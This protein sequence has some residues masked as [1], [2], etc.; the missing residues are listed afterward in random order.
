MSI[1]AMNQVW[2][3]SKQSGG[4]LLL[5]LAIADCANERGYCWPGDEYLAERIRMSERNTKRLIVKLEASGE[6]Y[7]LSHEGRGKK[8]FYIVATGLADADIECILIEVFKVAP[9]EAKFDIGEWRAGRSKKSQIKGDNMSPFSKT[10][11][12]EMQSHTSDKSTVSADNRIHP[13]AEQDEGVSLGG[14]REVESPEKSQ[15]KGDILSPFSGDSPVPDQVKIDDNAGAKDDKPS[16]GD[17]SAGEKGD[18]RGQKDD[19]SGSPYKEHEP[20][21]NPHEPPLEPP[22]EPS[23]NRHAR[24]AR[25]DDSRPETGLEKFFWTLDE[26][27]PG[28][29]NRKHV[30]EAFEKITRKTATRHDREL[31]ELTGAQFPFSS[32]CVVG[33]MERIKARACV[34][35]GSFAYF[36]TG[37]GE[38]FKRCDLAVKSAAKMCAGASQSQARAILLRAVRREIKSWEDRSP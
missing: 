38:I 29:F 26:G 28:G 12:A 21:W 22:V 20:S 6:L 1:E 15:I 17:D 25:A 19:K 37:L 35:I 2:K 11:S 34:P 24:G 18:I 33:L 16:S 7:R 10:D 36:R 4:G 3:Q 9:L 31:I 8:T 13:D 23:G 30:R 14:T 5:L 32:A 27:D